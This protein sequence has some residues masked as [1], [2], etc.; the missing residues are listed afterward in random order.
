VHI[1][2]GANS[3]QKTIRLEKPSRLPEGLSITPPLPE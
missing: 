2:K 1:D 3:R